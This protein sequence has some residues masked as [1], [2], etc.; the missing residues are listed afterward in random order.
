VHSAERSEKKSTNSGS[1]LQ[2]AEGR[3]LA[4]EIQSTGWLGAPTR[5][6]NMPIFF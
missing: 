3:E 4:F 1:V 5:G 2:Q 6:V